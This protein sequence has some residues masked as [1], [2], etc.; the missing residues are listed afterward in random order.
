MR[1]RQRKSGGNV[2]SE[3]GLHFLLFRY[4]YR[5][6]LYEFDF[7]LELILG[8]ISVFFLWIYIR[9]IY[10][11]C[12]LVTFKNIVRKLKVFSTEFSFIAIWKLNCLYISKVF[13]VL[14]YRLVLQSANC[15]I[16]ETV[17]RPVCGFFTKWTIWPKLNFRIFQY[18]RR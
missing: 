11:Y 9:F 5:I 1:K 12:A 17:A 10:R 16:V 7:I 2:R 18:A 15:V 4:F 3:Y 14:N 8:Y 13:T 6:I